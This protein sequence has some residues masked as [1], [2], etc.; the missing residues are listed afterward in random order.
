[1]SLTTFII[2]TIR[3][4]TLDRAIKSAQATNA[5]VLIEHDEKRIGPGL[6]RNKLI[7]RAKTEWVSMLDD[8][9]TVIPSYVDRLQEET[10]I[11]SDADVVMFRIYFIHGVIL[12]AWPNVYFG[13]IPISFSVKRDV[14]LE[15]PFKSEPYEDYEFIK[16]LDEAGKKIIW[17][18][19]LTYLMRQ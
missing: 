16:R 1:M 15:F 12:P 14:A 3:R 2:P 11:N 4:V 7:Q 6:T 17:S 8:D 13:N 5:E 18:K 19:Y 9:D 10:A